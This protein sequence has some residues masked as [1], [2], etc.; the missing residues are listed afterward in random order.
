LFFRARDPQALGTW[1]REH[2]GIGPGD[3]EPQGFPWT[4]E[5]GPT[6]F[7]PFAE[8]SDYFAADRR[9]MVDSRVRDLDAML[10][11]PATAG[12]E[13]TNREDVEYGRSARIQDPEG[14]P[15]ELWEPL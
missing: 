4:R 8:D 11:Q 15:I 13:A 1:Y 10:T 14:D 12:I 2:L 9:W 6:V 3:G 7:E 5:A